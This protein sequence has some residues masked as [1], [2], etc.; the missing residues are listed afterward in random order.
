MKISPNDPCPCHSGRKYKKCCRPYHAG[1]AAPTPQALMRARYAAYALDDAA[2]IMATTH[3][4]SDHHMANTTKW[5]AQIR[6]FTRNEF[7]TLEVISAEGDR[8]HFIATIISAGQP[9]ETEEYSLF[10]QVAGRW[11]YF[12]SLEADDTGSA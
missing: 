1:K 12:A 6:A 11:F 9:I 7:A 2:Y 4:D 5:E 8:V 3:P 10:K